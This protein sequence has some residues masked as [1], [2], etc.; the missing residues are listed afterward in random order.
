MDSP[1]PKRVEVDFDLCQGHA[2]CAAEAPDW[3]TVGK[4]SEA[5]VHAKRGAVPADQLAAVRDAVKYCPTQALR[6]VEN[7]N[8][9]E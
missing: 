8:P 1:T 4:G 6:L 9:Q 7:I 2:E 5:K 3:F